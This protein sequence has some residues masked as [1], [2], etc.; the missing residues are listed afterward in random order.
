MAFLLFIQTFS[1][2]LFLSFAETIFSNS[3][4]SGLANFAPTV[5]AEA[6]ITAGASSFRSLLEPGQLESVLLAYNQSLVHCF[7][8]AAATAAAVFVTCWGMGWKDVRESKRVS[9]RAKS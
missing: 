2:A 5:D 3:L 9:A 1:G 8:L 4:V 6:V 7:Y